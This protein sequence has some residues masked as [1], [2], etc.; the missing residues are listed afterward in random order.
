MSNIEKG[1]AEG[2]RERKRRDTL[3]RIA[4]VALEL[5]VARGYDATTLDDIAAAAGISRRTFFYYYES[6]EQILQALKGKD[7][8]GAIRSGMPEESPDEPPLAATSQCLINLARRYDDKESIVIDQLI[9][10]TD[11]LRARK[12]AFYVQMEETLFEALSQRYPGVRRQPALRV[13]AMASMGAWRL[14]I[15]LWRQERAKRP[16]AD[17]LRKQFELLQE[18]I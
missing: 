12:Q 10:A 15:D 13:V 4:A 2:L 18:E 11:G 1:A 5:F 8:L 7:L 9:Q 16:F 14:A 3:Q 6:K 17:Y